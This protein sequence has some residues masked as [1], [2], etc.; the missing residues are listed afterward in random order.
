MELKIVNCFCF[1]VKESGNP[2]AII[3]RFSGGSD[4]KQE[5]AKNLNLP[6]TVFISYINEAI[7][8][9]LHGALGAGYM[10]YQRTPFDELVCYTKNNNIIIIRKKDTDI[11]QVK[12]TA[13]PFAEKIIDKKF[14]CK[15][16]N[17]SNMEEIIGNLPLTAASVGSPK[18]LV[19][20]SSYN[21]LAKLTPNFD[22]IAQWSIES[23]I[24]GLYVYT[25]D[26]QST[27]YQFY[28]CAFN[29]KTG[30]NE[31]AATGV[32][33]AS[34]S[35]VLK[36]DISIGQGSFVKHPSILNV[37]FESPQEIWVGGK[38]SLSHSMDLK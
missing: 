30:N 22:L 16:L 20:V 4:A 18:L 11:F 17:L 9:C 15:M 26:A 19:P 29:P 7:H 32:A 35:F 33:A 21:T 5:L 6:V 10:I 24:N 37:S 8:F 25:R 1:D 36:Q 31:D 12:V 34:L 27:L 13:Q 28:A 14:I 3:E 23:G 38:V 2:A